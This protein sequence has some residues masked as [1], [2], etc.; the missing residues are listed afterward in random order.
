M[1]D[2][3]NITDYKRSYSQLEE[4]ALFCVLVS[5]MKADRC[6]IALDKLLHRITP[7]GLHPDVGIFMK[8]R[9]AYSSRYMPVD[10][11]GSV[12]NE[13][14]F[15]FHNQKA[16]RILGLIQ[17]P[18]NLATCTHDE[19]LACPGFGRKAINFFLL[20]SREDYIS[21]VLDT[22]DLTLVQRLAWAQSLR[23]LDAAQLRQFASLKDA[24][25]AS[26][27]LED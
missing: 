13:L 3:Q 1:I 15:R 22:H 9:A 5:G 2:P 8:M 26:T 25:D 12:F 23:S 19:L 10:Y 6:A 11:L 17:T 4:F 21:A 27:D 24:F 18:I 14:G 20:H 16:K 7:P